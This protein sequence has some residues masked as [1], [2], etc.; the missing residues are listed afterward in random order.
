VQAEITFLDGSNGK[1][2]IY[3]FF[4]PASKIFLTLTA[5]QRDAFPPSGPEH[6]AGPL[7]R[8]LTA[9]QRL[10][11]L[12]KTPAGFVIMEST[13]RASDMND[14]ERKALA[15][16]N[17]NLAALSARKLGARDKGYL[18]EELS[19]RRSYFPDG[20]FFSHHDARPFVP[21]RLVDIFLQDELTINIVVE[22]IDTRRRIQM[23]AIRRIPKDPKDTHPKWWL[24]G[25]VP[26][27]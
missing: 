6:W 4:D 13:D 24:K 12:R 14:A 11:L 7:A 27:N 20:F 19:I 10:I 5:W 16:N 25:F 18:R 23:T 26:V 2:R 15:W 3:I 21:I 22:S 9:Q 8:F 17:E 1:S